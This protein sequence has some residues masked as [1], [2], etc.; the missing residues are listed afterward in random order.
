MLCLFGLRCVELVVLVMLL[1]GAYLRV[2]CDALC[3]W[4]VD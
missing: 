1:V 3:F 4:L 2:G